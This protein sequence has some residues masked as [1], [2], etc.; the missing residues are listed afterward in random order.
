MR[1]FRATYKDRSGETRTA[2]KW[3][4]EF[5]DPSGCVRRLPAFENKSASIEYGRKLDA[6]S[7]CCVAGETPRGDLAR[8]VE[9]LPP[10]TQRKFVGLGLLD[11]Q[12]TATAKPLSKHVKAF[13]EALAAKDNTTGYVNTTIARLKAVLKGCGFKYWGDI[14][15]SRVE[16]WLAKERDGKD[17]IGIQT[18]NYYLRAVKQFCKWMV[19]DRRAGE[20][21]VAHLRTLNAAADQRRTRRALTHKEIRALLAATAKA[22][23][24]AKMSGTDRAMLYRVALETGLRWSEIASLTRESF[25]LDAQPP[26]VRVEA[27]Y[28][29]HRREDVLP[30]REDTA[31]VLA[32]YMAGRLPDVA[33]FRMPKTRMGAKM[34]RADLE[35][36]K[37][38]DT[39]GLDF[40]ALRHSFITNL[41]R[42]GVTPKVAQDLAR[43][44]D[45]N[46]TLSRYTHTVVEDRA[47]A[48]EALPDLTPT[49]E[50]E[51]L[52]QTGTD[53][54]PVLASC[55]ASQEPFQAVSCDELRGEKGDEAGGGNAAS[56]LKTGGNA[57]IVRGSGQCA[58][59]AELAD[60]LDL[61]FSGETHPG[62][63]PGP[64]TSLPQWK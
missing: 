52:R 39:D 3:Y 54:V 34:V 48:V 38:M 62:S 32:G 18:S 8:W 58:R 59:M 5:R 42:A 60:A 53:A 63:S 51:S 27:A 56:P 20:S 19:Q 24:I 37:I 43:H 35:A 21:P 33:A 61:G 46:L 36:A 25:R 11:A 40:H 28:S 55:L 57:A 44:S 12:R 26:T 16:V 50:A 14:E 23:R 22:G 30:L 6:L 7:A 47:E 31:A 15:A 10:K 29:K 1:V 9:T 13:E 2:A 4:I 45:I 17:G 41:A 49:D 64:R